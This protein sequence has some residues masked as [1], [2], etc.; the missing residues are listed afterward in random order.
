MMTDARLQSTIGYLLRIGVYTSLGTVALG[1]IFYLIHHG[2]E[3]AV[4]AAYQPQHQ[5]MGAVLR[6]LF[7]NLAAGNPEALMLLGT[8]MLFATP[9]LRLLFSLI[10]FLLERDKLY[11]AITLIVLA[12]IC[13][14]IAGGLG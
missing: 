6:Q 12:I 8:M 10:G 2:S 3:Q 4:Y 1:G 13:V 14:S 5:P 7:A 11:V 9:I